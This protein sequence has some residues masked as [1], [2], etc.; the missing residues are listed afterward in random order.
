MIKK[1]CLVALLFLFL[2]HHFVNVALAD[3]KMIPTLEE[4]NFTIIEDKDIRLKYI[5][6]NAIL[7]TGH[8]EGQYA[9]INIKVQP[10]YSVSGYIFICDTDFFVSGVW[11]KNGWIN[12]YDEKNRLYRFRPDMQ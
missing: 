4:K 11:L 10:N 9:R 5:Q 3:L 7:L 12:L 8:I 6:S 1:K 2:L